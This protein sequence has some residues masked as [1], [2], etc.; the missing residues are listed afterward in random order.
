M[1]NTYSH[2]FSGNE[3]NKLQAHEVV[4]L[5]KTKQV[6]PQEL[7]DCAFERIQ[8]V[9]P[10][11]NATIHIC[12]KRAYAAAKNVGTCSEAHS[13]W[14][15]G[16]PIGIKDLMTIKGVRTTFGSSAFTNFV[17]EI[18]DPLID[19]LESRG[20]VIVGKTNTPEFGVGGVTFNEVY[21]PTLNPWNTKLNPGGSSG[22]AAASLA[23]GEVWLSH[24][25]DHGGSLRTPAAYCGI[26]GLRPSPGIA[27]GS[28]KEIAFMREG[29]QGPM[30]RS[31]TDCA[32]FLDAMSGFDQQFPISF[33]EP[34]T[35][36]Q[37]A[38][39]NADKNIKIAFSPNLNNISPI[40]N[41][42]SDHLIKSIETIAK[43]V[44]A[45]EE[46]K[47]NL[48]N[49]K[50]TYLTLRGIMWVAHA[51]RLP[52]EVSEQ[53][54]DTLRENTNFGETIT[55]TQCADAELNR[56]QL[57]YE[58]IEVFSKF[59]VLA[60]PTVGC[61]PKPITE[62]WVTEIDGIKLPHYMDWLGFAFL[63]TVTGLPAISVPIG[64]NM[65]GL[66][67][68][69]QL[70]GGPRSEAKLLAC[71][72]TIEIIMNGPNTPIDPQTPD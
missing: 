11:I 3:L 29:V 27:G 34:M 15:A 7:L 59:D 61:M 63:A 51:R 69:I 71:A 64:F 53:F 9:S 23:S 60:C 65:A 26:V 28:S 22:G 48:T 39:Q 43:S 57:Y 30:A 18:S 8:E 1:T 35:S 46:V 25:S 56:S 52:K 24:G 54:K 31:V 36:Y 44:S 40:D 12:K 66:P 16:L 33:P 70:I 72:R 2:S 20:A 49:L 13:G 62:E 17:P 42:V 41:E 10:K 6:S 4:N 45:V 68:G 50:S 19:L 47:L 37:E 32:L 5:L 58:M 38:V 55:A 14:L 21:G 67:V